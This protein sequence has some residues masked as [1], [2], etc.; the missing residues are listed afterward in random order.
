MLRTSKILIKDQDFKEFAIDKVY[1]TRHFENML[2]I[3]LEQDY[4]QEIGDRKLI[5]N[6]YVMRAVIRDTKGGKY[7]EK[8]AYMKEKYKDHDLMQDLI[9][10]GKQL[11]KDNLVMTIRK[12]RGN[13]KSFYTKNKS[14]DKKAK[15]PKPKSLSSLNHYT[16]LIDND[17]GLGLSYLK[18]GKD[19]LG[20]TLDHD[21]GRQYIRVNQQNLKQL[22]DGDL[23]NIQSINLQYSNGE[24]YLLVTYHHNKKV[25]N[26]N[27]HKIAGLDIGINNLAA[28]YIEDKDSPSL[29]VDGK[30]F[31]NYNSQFNR[32]IAKLSNAMDTLE[33]KA[34]KK[35]L[36]IYINYLFE[37]RNRFF[38]DQF[39]KASKR[40][41]E[42][43]DKHN[44]T[45]LVISY[46][47][48]DIKNNGN[49]NM[50]KKTK[51]NFI[52]I[53]FIKLLEYLE[54]K[55]Q[56]FG[57]EV[58]V[59]DEGCTSKSNSFTK[60]VYKAKSLQKKIKDLKHQQDKTESD[61]EYQEY[62]RLID[63][64]K[65]LLKNYNY[66]GERVKRGLY[67]DDSNDL[68]INS[69]I[70]GARNILKLSPN[71]QEQKCTNLSKL[72]NPIKVNSDYE[73]AKLLKDSWDYEI[74]RKVV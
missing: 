55:A 13:F 63:A 20:I 52:Q 72:C 15:P 54:Y 66:S 61:I 23:D 53:P 45:E 25:Q 43:L 56:D 6:P 32:Q 30:K 70:N 68:A 36:R 33:S 10:V 18:K 2:L 48:N 27:P 4:K 57:I 8:V 7:A 58:T 44:V 73:F 1:L 22:V 40:M 46:T 47:L 67:V 9:E 65:K 71:Y 42:Y 16:L 50:Q 51:Q 24:L 34:R 49:C 38:Y 62:Q 21:R 3:L 64:C 26:N 14:D 19:K 39:H 35:Y 31:K 41:L 17:K 59:V 69:D 12:V 29:I 28:I 37:K 5:S 11:K 60:E 74:K